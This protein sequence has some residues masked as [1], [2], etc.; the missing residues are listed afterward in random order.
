VGSFFTIIL[1]SSVRVLG[2]GDFPGLSPLEIGM[3]A[4]AAVAAAEDDED[5][6]GG[7]D[8]FGGVLAVSRALDSEIDDIGDLS[9]SMA[10][11]GAVAVSAAIA[12]SI[13]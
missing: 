7:V 2:L 4:C 11:S 9:V 8:F 13:D 1:G 3:G 5:A 10:G 6:E 12:F